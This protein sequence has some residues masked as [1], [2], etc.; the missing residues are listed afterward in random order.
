MALNLTLNPTF[1][2]ILPA[3]VSESWHLFY[4][5][6]HKVKIK[7]PLR[8]SENLQR[9]GDI[10]EERTLDA[11]SYGTVNCWFILVVYSADRLV[12]AASILCR[13]LASRR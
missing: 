3:V 1:Y 10:P 11:F 9:T 2:R 13:T 7:N 8:L 6:A 5:L 4:F 12:F